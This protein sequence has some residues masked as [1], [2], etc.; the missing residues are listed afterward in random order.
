[1]SQI[2]KKQP[3]KQPKKQA[4]KQPKK[5]AKLPPKKMDDEWRYI[6]PKWRAHW[7][8]GG[9]CRRRSAEFKCKKDGINCD[10]CIRE[11]EYEKG[12]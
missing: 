11:S 2:E 7:T 8:T 9:Y 12:R 3:K 4:K 6:H 5:Q 10:K 1:M